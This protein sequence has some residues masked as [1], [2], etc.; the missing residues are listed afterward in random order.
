M[1][2]RFKVQKFTARVKSS[3]STTSS[4][5][6]RRHFTSGESLGQDQRQFDN[7]QTLVHRWTEKCG[8]FTDRGIKRGTDTR[9]EEI[10]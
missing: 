4:I 3:D 7:G 6:V 8:S 9:G 5:K 2:R 10:G 1:Y